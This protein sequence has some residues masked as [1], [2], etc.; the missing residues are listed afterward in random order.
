MEY[1]PV[2]IL[3]VGAV[4]GLAGIIWLASGKP[5]TVLRRRLTLAGLIVHPFATYTLFMVSVP[6]AR[7]GFWPW[8]S[9][10]LMMLGLP[11][12]GWVALCGAGYWLGGRRPRAVEP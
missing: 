5:S 4:A 10:G 11:M 12:L 1:L 8:Y 9:V 2:T 7:G 3:V 6:P